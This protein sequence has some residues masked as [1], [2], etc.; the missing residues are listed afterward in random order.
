MNINW[1]LLTPEEIEWYNA[2]YC[3]GLYTR[4]RKMKHFLEPWKIERICFQMNQFLLQKQ[5]ENI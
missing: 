5:K 2:G 1:D 4:L 3:N